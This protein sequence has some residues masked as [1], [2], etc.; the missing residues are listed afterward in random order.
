[1]HT[2]ISTG[3]RR[4][5]HSLTQFSRC[6]DPFGTEQHL[7]SKWRL[8]LGLLVIFSL[9]QWAH[10][11]GS[12]LFSTNN[13]RPV[14]FRHNVLSLLSCHYQVYTATHTQDQKNA[15]LNLSLKN[16]CSTDKKKTRTEK[17]ENTH[18]SESSF[19]SCYFLYSLPPFLLFSGEDQGMTACTLCSVII[20]QET[21]WREWCQPPAETKP[22]WVV[23]FIIR[24]LGSI[25]I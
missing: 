19:Q 21:V 25:Y 15:T 8:V 17:K 4:V 6:N 1:M 7:F 11:E 24:K 12:I 14:L 18:H 2:N 13:Q 22:S 20:N 3:T 10:W 23:F 5:T 9:T 16:D